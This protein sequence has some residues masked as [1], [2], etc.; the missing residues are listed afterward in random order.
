MGHPVYIK[1][2][3]DQARSF[4]KNPMTFITDDKNVS[5]LT[6]FNISKKFRAKFSSKTRKA[7]S[8]LRGSMMYY[9]RIKKI[10]CKTHYK[11]QGWNLGLMAW[12]VSIKIKRSS[13]KC[14]LRWT[15]RGLY[16]HNHEIFTSPL[17][18]LFFAL[19]SIK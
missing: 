11:V 2:V 16:A 19:C 9:V 8:T 7:F 13:L 4:I 15:L 5:H 12:T 18:C 1:T 17:C 3:S 10:Y 14:R 6:N